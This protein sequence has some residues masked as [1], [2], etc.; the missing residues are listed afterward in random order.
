MVHEMFSSNKICS[1]YRNTFGKFVLNKAFLLLG[2]EEKMELKE[3]IQKK[4]N[5]NKKTNVKFK[6]LLEL[7]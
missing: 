2:H 1:L 4:I 6:E 5:S 7:F 3:F